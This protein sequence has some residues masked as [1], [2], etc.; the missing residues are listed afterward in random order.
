M[1][2]VAMLSGSSA[3]EN[4]CSMLTIRRETQGRN[5]FERWEYYVW[6]WGNTLPVE[7]YI[8]VT[9]GLVGC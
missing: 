3:M 8:T 4:A 2:V 6:A 1:H 7:T 5:S 9:C